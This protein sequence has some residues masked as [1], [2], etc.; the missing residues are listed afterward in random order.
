MRSSLEYCA[1]AVWHSHNSNETPKNSI[2]QR[3]WYTEVMKKRKGKGTIVWGLDKAMY[4]RIEGDAKTRGRMGRAEGPS[5]AVIIG[6]SDI[7]RGLKR[8]NVVLSSRQA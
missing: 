7:A 6:P 2:L 8:R 5:K 1:S 3:A 4:V